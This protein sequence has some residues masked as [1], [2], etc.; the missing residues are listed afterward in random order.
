MFGAGI[1]CSPQGIEADTRQ[2][3]ELCQKE[4]IQDIYSLTKLSPSNTTSSVHMVPIASADQTAAEL[5][6][7]GATLHSA[8]VSTSQDKL[9][10]L[11]DNTS[12]NP[13]IQGDLTSQFPMPAHSCD[14]TL[15]TPSSKL[16]EL[17]FPQQSLPKGVDAGTSTS[18]LPDWN[19]LSR[20]HDVVDQ[21]ANTTLD[22]AQEISGVDFNVNSLPDNRRTNHD[23]LAHNTPVLNDFGSDTKRHF[24]IQSNVQDPSLAMAHYSS[25]EH[26]QSLSVQLCEA[27][28]SRP[29]HLP[30]Q[31]ADT[32]RPTNHDRWAQ[33]ESASIASRFHTQ[34]LSNPPYSSTP[35]SQHVLISTPAKTA[36][37]H[38]FDS[39]SSISLKPSEVQS[40]LESMLSPGVVD[41][42]GTNPP[43]R[44]LPVA[45]N[46]HSQ[47]FPISSSDSFVPSVQLV[48]NSEMDQNSPVTS[49]QTLESAQLPPETDSPKVS[50]S[51]S[52][53]EL[54][55]PLHIGSLFENSRSE[56]LQDP[57]KAPATI[58]SRRRSS[59]DGRLQFGSH[60]GSLSSE[61]GLGNPRD[62]KLELS[63]SRPTTPAANPTTL[64]TPTSCLSDSK[65][66]PSHLAIASLADFV[67]DS[68]LDLHYT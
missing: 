9:G 62:I 7:S 12:H 6:S 24:E 15:A 41:S 51:A 14:L 28:S 39:P 34:T 20:T 10:V 66:P 25:S 8:F 36:S 61:H 40:T 48:L 52:A 63:L 5:S 22:P 16:L 11:F 2:H 54:K 59:L 49:Q 30:T 1:D 26:Y 44:V 46:S 65:Y 19:S 17:N 43:P 37:T 13:S 35:T 21:F 64:G 53:S 18:I 29:L 56:S 4:E 33:H 45:H 57:F 50:L 27:P 47:L 58:G 23:R 42:R 55:Y 60:R 68:E 3:P 67:G 31:S 38:A 32:I